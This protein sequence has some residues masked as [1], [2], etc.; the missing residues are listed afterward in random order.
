[1]SG[2]ADVVFVMSKSERFVYDRI[3]AKCPRE[4]T[5]GIIGGVL[6]ALGANI[7]VGALMTAQS[8]E[9]LIPG[10]L[11]LAGGFVWQYFFWGKAGELI[12]TYDELVKKEEPMGKIRTKTGE[13][14][15]E[16]GRGTTILRAYLGT[17]VLGLACVGT[18]AWFRFGSSL[19][20]A[21]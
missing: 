8:L 12:S 21:G 16:D 2:Q 14:L 4:N 19:C 11:G 17:W 6:F 20:R 15:R 9:Y 18:L 13:R 1:M 10:V 3:L 7:V 5:S